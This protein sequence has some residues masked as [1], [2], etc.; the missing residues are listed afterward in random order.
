[1]IDAG[2]WLR[3]A[4]TA[5]DSRSMEFT[6]EPRAVELELLAGR[7]HY[8]RVVQQ[9]GAAELAVWIAT[10]N[11]KEL[12]VEER[13]SSM[14]RRKK[15]WHS[16]LEVFDGLAKRGVELRILHATR[17]SRAFRERL[18]G[19]PELKEGGLELRACPRVHFKAVII[20]AATLYL[21]SA[22]WT[23]AGLGGKGVNRRN[24]ELGMI[25]RDEGYIDR[26]QASFAD[27]WDG[28][29]CPECRVRE[30]C[31]LPLDGLSK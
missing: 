11:L 2:I 3:T 30:H 7:A 8:E 26:V 20:D 28:G 5:Y 13:Q 12:M 31:E 4:T 24:F 25:T 27:I 6:T 17:P 14:F 22:N 16:V 15:R 1:M 9:V 21:G 29:Q 10:A 23:G 18:D 19:L